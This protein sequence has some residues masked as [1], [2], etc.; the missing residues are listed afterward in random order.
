MPRIKT[1]RTV[2]F[3]LIL[4]RIY[5]VAM[6][7][8]I[9]SK[10]VIEARGRRTMQARPRQRE[11]PRGDSATGANPNDEIRLSAESED[12]C[13]GRPGCEIGAEEGRRDA[14]TTNWRRARNPKQIQR[15]KTKSQRSFRFWF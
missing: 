11:A 9:L 4:L 1:T 3:A 12:D 5:L 2:T 8:I 10:F 15:G 13:C 6:L 7:L 14:R